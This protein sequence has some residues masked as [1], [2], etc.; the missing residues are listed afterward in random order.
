MFEEKKAPLPNA[1]FPEAEIQQIKGVSYRHDII[2][3]IDAIN[4]GDE[5][6]VSRLE[7][8]SRRP[9]VGTHSEFISRLLPRARDFFAEIFRIL[10]PGGILIIEL[11]EFAKCAQKALE[12]EGNMAEYLEAVRGLYAFGVDQID[13]REMFMPYAFGWSN[14]HLKQELEKAGFLQIKVCD[15]QT[16][17]QRAWRDI[18][19]ESSKPAFDS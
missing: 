5:T 15:A 4:R 3:A 6:G 16:H 7:E 8:I 2:S 18:R 9:G 12:C 13:H 10:E 1:E 17:G 14:W 11:P 19:I